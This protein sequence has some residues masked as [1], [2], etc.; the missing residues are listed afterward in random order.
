[1]LGG[2]PG[3]DLR[4]TR[5]RIYLARCLA[6]SGKLPEAVKQLEGVIAGTPDK[7]VKAVAYNALGDVYRSQGRGKD[8]LWPYLWVDVIYHQNREEHLKAIEQLA[9]LFDEQGDK[10]RAKEYRDKVK[11]ETR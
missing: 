9:K 8:A 4:A 7:T 11:R 6:G 5:A 1:M 10:T 2:L 3:D